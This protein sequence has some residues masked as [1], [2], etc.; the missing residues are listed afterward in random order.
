MKLISNLSDK[1]FD[2]DKEIFSNFVTNLKE[3]LFFLNLQTKSIDDLNNAKFIL[4]ELQLKPIVS[5]VTKL[6]SLKSLILNI[7]L[8]SKRVNQQYE[9]VQFWFRDVST[10]APIN[11]GFEIKTL[12]EIDDR[13]RTLPEIL[14]SEI[15]SKNLESLAGKTILVG[16]DRE[17]Y[18]WTVS[19]L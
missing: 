5:D 15:F 7:F 4:D 13:L 1:L 19:T 2:S 18:K 9:M 10:I 11:I 12:E 16:F 14:Q 6:D 8:F 17:N 3:R